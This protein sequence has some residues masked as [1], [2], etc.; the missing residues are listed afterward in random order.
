MHCAIC[1]SDSDAVTELKSDCP[2]CEEAISECLQGYKDPDYEDLI[3][4]EE[5]LPDEYSIPEVGHARSELDDRS[6]GEGV[7]P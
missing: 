7:E 5:E 1:D 2:T 6:Y 3:E 4:E